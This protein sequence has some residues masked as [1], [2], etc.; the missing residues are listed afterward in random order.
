MLN[1]TTFLLSMRG[2]PYYYYGDELAMTNAGF[3]KIE[4]YKDMPTLNEYLH[5]KNIGGDLKKYMEFIKFSC[6]DNGRTPMQWDS[7]SH[8]GFTTGTPWLQTNAN[9]KNINVTA[10]EKDENSCLN[11]FKKMVK[12]RK[13]NEVLVYGKFTSIDKENPDV[14]AYTRE[15]NGKKMLM[16]LN[17]RN[18]KVS[19]ETGIDLGKAKLLISNYKTASVSGTLQPYEAIVY[20]L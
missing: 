18:K 5:Q 8:A 9:Y 17:F 12:L 11:Y 7:S 15:L 1:N 10:Q 16:L 6:R 13:E 2:T 4:D 20:E 3:E 19:F 14:F